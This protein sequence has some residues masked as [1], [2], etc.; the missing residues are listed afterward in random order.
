MD[1][2]ASVQCLR[3]CRQTWNTD[4]LYHVQY[5]SDAI[6]EFEGTS[7][8]VRVTIA[9]GELA[10]ARGDVEGAI[11][12]VGVFPFP[13]LY[14]FLWTVTLPKW[15]GTMWGVCSGCVLLRQRLCM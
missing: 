8:E 3:W 13:A 1:V 11:K 12:K 10:I 5:I 15:G 9:D 14:V 6:R 7:E 2:P 4:V